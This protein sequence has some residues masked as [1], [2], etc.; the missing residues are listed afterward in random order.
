MSN[1]NKYSGGE[2]EKNSASFFEKFPAASEKARSVLGVDGARR[3]LGRS[4][5]AATAATADDD[6]AEAA[7][8]AIKST[9]EYRPTE[10]GH[11]P[12]AGHSH[13]PSSVDPNQ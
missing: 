1:V 5:T 12:G 6:E 13:E 11:S 10:P 3:A 9:D 7:A 8:V 4:A 2:I